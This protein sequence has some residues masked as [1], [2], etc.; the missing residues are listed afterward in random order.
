[1]KEGVVM[2]DSIEPTGGM[3]D[4]GLIELDGTHNTRDQGGMKTVTGQ[5]VRAKRLIRSD[6][7]DKL[8]DN[9]IHILID[10]CDLR[11]VIDLRTDVEQK[12]APDPVDRMPG[13]KHVSLPVLSGSAVGLTHEHSLRSLWNEFCKLKGDPMGV[14]CETYPLML[15]DETGIAAYKQLFEIL[16]AQEQGAVLWHCSEGKDRTGIASMLVLFALGV[17]PETIMEDYLATNL[18]ARQKMKRIARDLEKVHLADKSDEALLALIC[19]H[20]EYI[21]AAMD[22]LEKEYG[23]LDAYLTEALDLTP[24]KRKLLADLYLF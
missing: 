14:I 6:G 3:T 24:A 20:K 22:A 23:S 18:F 8:S 2:T 15:L 16:L 5:R 13:V 17:P 9:D 11:T 21:D 12:A 4:Y 7:L 1:M 10:E 19:A